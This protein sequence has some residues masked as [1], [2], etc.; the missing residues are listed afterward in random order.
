MLEVANVEAGYGKIQILNNLSLSAK[1]NKLT[2]LIGPNGAGKSTLLKTIFGFVTPSKGSIRFQGEEI[3]GLPSHKLANLGIGFLLQRVSVF[4]DLTIE[5]NLKLGAW[6]FK[7]DSARVAQR[8]E[9]MYE[10]FPILKQKRSESAGLMSGGQK[11]ML[12][13]ARTLMPGPRLILVDE[14]SAGLSP[15]IAK[16][17]YRVLHELRDEGITLLMVDQNIRESIGYSDHVYVLERGQVSSESAAD[18]IEKNLK[19]VVESWLKF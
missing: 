15:K 8:I 7:K 3:S 19:Q 1:E 6:S 9:C 2:L 4:P 5:E 11:R 17:V 18:E 12:E 10:K 13:I 14:P 16:E